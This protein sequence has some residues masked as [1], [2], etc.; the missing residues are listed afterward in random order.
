M[1]RWS[2]VLALLV[3][4]GSLGLAGGQLMAAPLPQ[5]D[6]VVITSPRDNANVR[7][8]VE[9]VGTAAHPNFESYGVLYAAGPGPTGNSRWVTIVFGVEEQVVDG[10]L[11]VWDTAARTEDGQPVVPNGVYTLA[12]VR[13]REGGTEPDTQFFVRNVSVLN[14]EGEEEATP[15]PTL[16]P[17]P[18]AVPVTPTP[19]PVDMPPTPT[20]RPTAEPGVGPA[21]AAPAEGEGEEGGAAALDVGRLRGAFFDGVKIALLLFVFWGLYTLGKVVVRYYLRTGRIDLPWKKQ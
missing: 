13:Y 1:R 17:L 10:V 18:T 20:P 21:P 3:L 15:T 4:A 16:P 14:E 6:Q 8:A 9:I 5:V 7:G 2:K 19:V 11:A 12:L